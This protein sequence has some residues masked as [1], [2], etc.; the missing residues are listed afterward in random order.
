MARKPKAPSPE[1]PAKPR[2]K[3]TQE[4]Q[5][6]L[7]IETARQLGVDETGAEFESSF[8][9]ITRSVQPTKRQN[10]SEN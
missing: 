2:R 9:R 4:E 1:K 8:T 5:S 3:M 7:F 10:C 6:A